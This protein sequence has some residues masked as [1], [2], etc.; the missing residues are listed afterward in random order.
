MDGRD[1]YEGASWALRLVASQLAAY[2]H[3][4]VR[5]PPPAQ[6]PPGFLL[7]AQFYNADEAKIDIGAV[8]ALV[9]ERQSFGGPMLV[10]VRL[11]D[12][13]A[14]HLLRLRWAVVDS[15]LHATDRLVAARLLQ[16]KQVSALGAVD[17]EEFATPA[18][19][20]GARLG[21]NGQG[22]PQPGSLIASPDGGPASS[23][24]PRC[25]LPLALLADAAGVEH[26]AANAS[27]I[28]LAPAAAQRQL[29]VLLDPRCAYKLWLAP[30]GLTYLP[31]LLLAHGATALGMAAAAMLLVLAH[32]A[33]LVT[34]VLRGQR[35]IAPFPPAAA[36]APGVPAA[37]GMAGAPFPL[38]GLL[39]GPQSL[40]SS[41][42]T[43]HQAAAAAAAQN[44]GSQVR[45]ISTGVW[46]CCCDHAPCMCSAQCFKTRLQQKPARVTSTPM[47]CLVRRLETR[48]LAAAAWPALRPSAGLS[49]PCRCAPAR[50]RPRPR[51][52]SRCCAA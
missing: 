33:L 1:Y 8:S 12:L 27:G 39:A 50:P 48:L 47:R 24:A 23:A 44:G 28:N 51:C 40:I 52:R 10:S 7:S 41:A 18:A 21:G 13:F 14:P 26:V 19:P 16:Q 35:S 3:L 4:S 9:A 20:R 25:W 6:L 45:L 42:F 11:P 46:R 38:A 31:P 2:T 43:Q 5:L 17:P 36:A 22:D 37:A 49:V 34:R 29:V 15:R 30:D 32:Q